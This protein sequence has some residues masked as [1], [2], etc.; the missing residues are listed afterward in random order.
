MESKVL[1]SIPPEEGY[2][3]LRGVNR[4]LVEETVYPVTQKYELAPQ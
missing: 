1:H 3:L 4:H 2:P